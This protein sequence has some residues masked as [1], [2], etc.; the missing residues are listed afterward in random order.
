MTPSQSS[1][2]S[3]DGSTCISLPHRPAFILGPYEG[4]LWTFDFFLPGDF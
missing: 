1:D 2:F 3:V 4:C